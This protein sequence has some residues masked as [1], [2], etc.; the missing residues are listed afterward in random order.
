MITIVDYGAGNLRSIVGAIAKL[1][2]LPVITRNPHVVMS[3]QIVILPGA[4]AATDIIKFTRSRNHQPDSTFYC[5]RMPFLWCL[6]R[7]TYVL[8][9]FLVWYAAFLHDKGFHT[10]DGIR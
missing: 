3:T 7:A 10:W 4:G 9:A 1:C 6:Y 8:I 2:Y 5:R